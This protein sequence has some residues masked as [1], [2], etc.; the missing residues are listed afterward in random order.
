MFRALGFGGRVTSLINAVSISVII[1]AI[2]LVI[3]FVIV[4][5]PPRV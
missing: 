3:C 2:I 5:S 4:T 1:T